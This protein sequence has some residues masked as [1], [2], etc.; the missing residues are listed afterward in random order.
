MKIALSGKQ[1][2]GKSELAQYLIKTYGFVHLSFAKAIKEYAM[3][4][5]Q[6]TWEQAFG[7]EKN[8]ELLQKIGREGREIN[9]NYW[10]DAILETITTDPSKN[11]IIDDV[12]YE[13]EYDLLKGHNFVMV[14]IEADEN[15]RKQ[16][17]E[18]TFIHP[19]H[20]SETAL[21]EGFQWDMVIH[22]IQT[23]E[24]LQRLGDM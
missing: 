6:L 23:I 1:G 19:N 2:S 15:L 8:R 21:D 12:R 16:R 18:M 22:N 13:N 5:H 7:K 14:R 4:H 10:V 24:V 3:E 9:I 17:L 11:Y 20:V